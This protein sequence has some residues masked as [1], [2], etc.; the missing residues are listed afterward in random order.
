VSAAATASTTLAVTDPYGLT[1]VAGDLEN[2]ERTRLFKRNMNIF[3]SGSNVYA[4]ITGVNANGT[5]TLNTAV[6]AAAG[7]L[8]YRGD[9]VGRTSVNNEITGITG[10]VK[11]TGNYLGLARTGFPEWQANLLQIGTGTGGTLTEQAMRIAMDTAETNGT[12]GPDL[13]VT[14][15]KTRR[16]YEALLQ[17]Q[18]RFTSPTKLEGGYSAIDF[19]GLPM[20][21]DKDAPP[22]RM[23][24]LRVA[25]MR[26]MVMAD[27]QWM[28]DD[29]EVLNRVTDKDAYS[30]VLYT[31]RELITTRPAN[32]TVLFDVT[33]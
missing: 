9:A 28:D 25:D 31:Y 26:W 8:I 29:G 33:A 23:F 1:Y 15:H 16:R 19:D 10:L 7:D 24:F 5:V 30:A 13:I 4:R 20:M 22:Q 3:I 14:N 11:S 12:A 2:S 6:T 27:T 17:S 18:R 32:Q 21:V